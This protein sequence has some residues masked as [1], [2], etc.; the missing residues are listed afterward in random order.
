MEEGA[1]S[2]TDRC[3]LAVGAGP[4]LP[5]SRVFRA[6]GPLK[7]ACWGDH[8]RDPWSDPGVGAG[9]RNQPGL[10]LLGGSGGRCVCLGHMRLH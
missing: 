8:G 1:P 7:G 4:L 5:K 9:P 3:S 6:H 10:A 2:P